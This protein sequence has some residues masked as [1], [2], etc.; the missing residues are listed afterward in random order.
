[1]NHQGTIR[2][3]TERLILRRFEMKDAKDMYKNVTSDP[4]VNKFLTW[5]LH[6]N[7]SETVSLLAGWLEG[8][9]DL[10]RYC[11]AIEL[12]KIGGVIGTIAS[13]TVRN[14]TETVDV[15]YCI[16]SKWWGKG[17]VLEALWEIIKFFFD[18]VQ[19][20]RIEAGYDI[21]N[22]NSGRVLEKIGMQK[23]GIIR[24]A[25]RNNQGLFDIVQ[26]SILREEWK[27]REV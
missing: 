1:M 20:N 22:P 12:K 26:C 15:T 9:Q 4:A 16:G 5:T 8:Y 17:I 24:Q 23:E 6:E 14:R 11:W 3:E 10:E 19:V 21:N 25:G 27:K 13:P 2:L 18:V 7:V